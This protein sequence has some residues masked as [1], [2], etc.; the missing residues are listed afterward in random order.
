M[1]AIVLKSCGHTYA[2]LNIYY[3]LMRNA[4]FSIF[5]YL[6]VCDVPVTLSAV[7]SS[8][9]KLS[10]QRGRSKSPSSLRARV[11]NC[12]KVLPVYVIHACVCA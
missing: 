11:K 5:W 10:E 3:R 12:E 1:R 4:V 6:M 2:I 9:L 8:L 7:S